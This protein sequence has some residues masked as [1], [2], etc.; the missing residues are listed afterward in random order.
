M[1][2]ALWAVVDAPIAEV[3]RRVC[4]WRATDESSTRWPALV[5]W[6]R[7]A[8]DALGDATLSLVAAAGRAAQIAIGRAP[9]DMRGS[10]RSVHVISSVPAG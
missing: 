9:R 8:R 6:A 2:L 7:A 1:A 10:A 3:G 5:R 4:A